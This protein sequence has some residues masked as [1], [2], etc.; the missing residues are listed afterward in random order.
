MKDGISKDVNVAKNMKVT[1][2]GRKDTMSMSMASKGVRRKEPDQCHQ[3]TCEKFQ[4]VSR[5]WWYESCRAE[6]LGPRKE[7]IDTDGF[8]F[9]ISSGRTGTSLSLQLPSQDWRLSL[10]KS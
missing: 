2:A 9:D 8:S 10:L 4:R 5:N 6:D 3:H 7:K 1:L